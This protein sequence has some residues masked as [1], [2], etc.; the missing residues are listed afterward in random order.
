MQS[1]ING[2]FSTATILIASA[3]MPMRSSSFLYTEPIIDRSQT[4]EFS[5]KFIA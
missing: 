2:L 4:G 5:V 1:T 3:F